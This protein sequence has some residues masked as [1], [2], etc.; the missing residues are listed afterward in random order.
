MASKAATQHVRSYR[1]LV[2]D[3]YERLCDSS[4]APH[5]L[6]GRIIT[7]DEQLQHSFTA[8]LEER[9]RSQRAKRVRAQADERQSSLLRLATRTQEAEAKL[10]DLISRARDVLGRTDAAAA[11][12]RAVTMSQLVDYAERVSYCNAAPYGKL[13]M[14]IAQKDGFRGGW[15]APSPQQHMLS[16]S[17][18]AVRARQGPGLEETGGSEAAARPEL[19]VSP[20][21]HPTTLEP[22]VPAVAFG[23]IL[24]QSVHTAGSPEDMAGSLD[25]NPD[26]DEDDDV[27]E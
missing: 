12:A 5:E 16:S 25:L 23:S 10:A 1:S 7:T 4:G 15:G 24:P 22:G 13:A 27:F 26:D 18:F 2:E 9:T 8:L 11:S 19:G 6:V 21:P 3:L 17:S 20:P 14:D